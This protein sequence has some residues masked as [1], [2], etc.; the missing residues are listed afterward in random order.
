MGRGQ[1][2]DH[3]KIKKK[4]NL[5]QWIPKVSA[6]CEQHAN[7]KFIIKVAHLI[8]PSAQIQE[9]ITSLDGLV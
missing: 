7:F 3:Q 9:L 2:L 8:I 5:S 4:K 1:Y 6:F